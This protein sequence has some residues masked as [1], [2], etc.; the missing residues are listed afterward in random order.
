MPT[1]WFTFMRRT[2]P[3]KRSARHRPLTFSGYELIKGLGATETISI[4][5]FTNHPTSARIGADIEQHLTVHPH[6]PPVLFIAG[7][8]I[9]AW[10]ADLAQAR[11]RVECLEAM[12]ELVTLTGRREIR[13]RELTLLLVMADHDA[14]EV[15]LRTDDARPDRQRTRHARNCFRPPADRA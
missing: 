5:V 10:G 8:G 4:P 2:R 15:R 1:R 12:C 11:D 6:A 13:D 14:A 7:H 9:T 3:P